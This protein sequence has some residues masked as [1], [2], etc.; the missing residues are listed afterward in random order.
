MTTFHY[1][2]FAQLADSTKVVIDIIE[3]VTTIVV[4]VEVE[5]LSTIKAVVKE[6]LLAAVV[7]AGWWLHRRRRRWW[8][9]GGRWSAVQVEGGK[10]WLAAS[11]LLHCQDFSSTLNNR[12]RVVSERT[13]R[14]RWIRQAS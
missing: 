1:D 8:G 7:A 4:E 5:A 12:R 9:R 14:W 3:A 11:R 6:P 13:S 10:G 2:I